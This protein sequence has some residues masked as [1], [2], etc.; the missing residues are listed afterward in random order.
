LTSGRVGAVEYHPPW[1]R[2]RGRYAGRFVAG[3]PVVCVVDLGFPWPTGGAFGW[4]PSHDLG[5]ALR[6]QSGEH[7]GRVRLA[8][9]VGPYEVWEVDR[10]LEEVLSAE[11]FP[12][13]SDAPSAMVS[14]ARRHDP[15]APGASP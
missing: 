12:L 7:P 9:R 6:R 13:S 4:P 11:P 5:R 8:C 3:R 14:G 1:P 2:L 15:A 10:P